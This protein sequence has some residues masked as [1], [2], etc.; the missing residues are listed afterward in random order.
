MIA[1]GT[2]PL[3]DNQRIVITG[4]GLSA[5]NGNTLRFDTDF[6]GRKRPEGHTIPGPFTPVGTGSLTDPIT[7]LTADKLP[8]H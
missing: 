7:H 5:P 8:G 2:Q 3:L 1:P 6:F 4:I